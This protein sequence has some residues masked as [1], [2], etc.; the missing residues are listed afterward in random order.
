MYYLAAGNETIS[1]DGKTSPL[2]VAVSSAS[3]RTTV[4]PIPLCAFPLL[5]GSLLFICLAKVTIL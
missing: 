1:I 4:F 2:P 3:N 5:L